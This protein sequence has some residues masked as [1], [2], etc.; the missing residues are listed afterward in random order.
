MSSVYG[1]SDSRPSFDFSYISI[2]FVICKQRFSLRRCIELRFGMLRGSAQ[3][4]PELAGAS[5]KG[6]REKSPDIPLRHQ[7][8]HKRSLPG[9]FPS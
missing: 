6:Y 3:E 9:F 7:L 1:H 2:L 4:T 8:V 5:W